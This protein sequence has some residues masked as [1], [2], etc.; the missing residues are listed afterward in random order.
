MAI[1]V[2]NLYNKFFDHCDQHPSIVD[3]VEFK[4]IANSVLVLATSV[5]VATITHYGCLGEFS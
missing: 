3:C 4:D 2:A 5:W 1:C